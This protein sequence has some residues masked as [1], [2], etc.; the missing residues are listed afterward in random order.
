MSLR[1]FDNYNL[2]ARISVIVFYITP[3]IFDF[4][5]V[6]GENFSFIE[7]ALITIFSVVFC[8]GLLNVCRPKNNTTNKNYAA[9]LL[10]S[11][12]SLS[13]EN[14]KRYYRKLSSF[15]P[16]F[17]KFKCTEEASYELCDS[18]VSWLRAKTRD[19]KDFPLVFEENINYGFYRNMHS[20]KKYGIML[21]SIVLIVLFSSIWIPFLDFLKQSEINFVVVSI[22]HIFEIVY[23][24]LVIT[25]NLVTE[26]AKRY[27]KALIEAI[28][29]L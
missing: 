9:T 1:I 28:D 25:K 8:Q 6:F 14:R 5:L 3:F 29:I 10:K 17:S 12:S 22:I 16:E 2:R 4:I 7:N 24:F 23:L 15:E 27:A 19:K 18:A 21:N 20:F 26:S 11:D 13:Q